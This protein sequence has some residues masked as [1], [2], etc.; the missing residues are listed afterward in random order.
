MRKKREISAFDYEVVRF[1]SELETFLQ[2]ELGVHKGLNIIIDYQDILVEP[3]KPPTERFYV[4]ISPIV[5]PKGSCIHAC[6]FQDS[7]SKL[8]RAVGISFFLKGWPFLGLTLK[9][10]GE[11]HYKFEYFNLPKK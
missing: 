1:T 7:S 4:F 11:S 8:W 6:F 9:C 10:S 3:L 5:W 2:L